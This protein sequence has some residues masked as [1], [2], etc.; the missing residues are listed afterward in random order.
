[1]IEPFNNRPNDYPTTSSA[2]SDYKDTQNHRQQN[3]YN[4]KKYT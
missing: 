2:L 4:Q 3:E 1:M